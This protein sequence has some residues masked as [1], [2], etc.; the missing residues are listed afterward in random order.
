MA[1][2]ADDAPQLAVVGEAY[3][4]NQHV[5]WRGCLGFSNGTLERRYS[6]IMQSPPQNMKPYLGYEGYNYAPVLSFAR[7]VVL[8]ECLMTGLGTP[9]SGSTN[10]ALPGAYVYMFVY[11]VCVYIYI[12][13]YTHTCYIYIYAYTYI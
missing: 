4:H 2:G 1:H 13:I 5:F 6:R 12:Y 8:S 3:A 9:A 7:T 11:N 10:F